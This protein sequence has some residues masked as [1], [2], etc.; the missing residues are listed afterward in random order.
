MKRKPKWREFE[1]VVERLQRVFY[2]NSVIERDAKIFGHKTETNRQIDVAIRQKIGLQ[3]ILIIVECKDWSSKVDAP[4]V[5]SFIGVKEDV[6]AHA[7]MMISPK[8]FSKAA[9][10]L[11]KK[12]NVNL[13]TLR[14]TRKESWPNGLLT[15]LVIDIW[16]L[17][18]Q[19][20]YVKDKDGSIK[21]LATDTE[22]KLHVNGESE[23]PVAT[24]C[25]RIWDNNPNKEEGRADFEFL[26]T[27]P[28]GAKDDK[29]L[30]LGIGFDAKKI[31]KIRF[32]RLHFEGFEHQDQNKAS[33]ASFTID[34]EEPAKSFDESLSGVECQGMGI[35]MDSTIVKTRDAKNVEIL[36]ALCKGHVTLTVKSKN[37]LSIPTGKFGSEAIVKM[38]KT[39][40]RIVAFDI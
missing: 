17:T 20:L 23:V 39:S 7:A 27:A 33:A 21:N 15:P 14:E 37:V 3:E 2:R 34:F 4:A 16:E 13:Y 8:G 26:S 31:K 1:E 24:F 5:E 18:P 40:E 22:A 12:A 36:D 10:R 25:R 28:A 29:E 32:G 19:A 6:R 30:V 11:A 9:V 35:V 38:A